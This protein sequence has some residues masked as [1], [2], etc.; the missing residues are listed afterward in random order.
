MKKRSREE[1]KEV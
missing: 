1:D